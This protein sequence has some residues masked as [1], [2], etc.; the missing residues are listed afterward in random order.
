MSTE[1]DNTRKM[2]TGCKSLGLTVPSKILRL[3]NVRPT[4]IMEFQRLNLKKTVACLI[5]NCKS[6]RELKQIHSHITTSPH[7]FI[8]DR[9]FLISRL[10]FFCTVSQSGSLSYANTVFKLVPRKTLFIYNAMIRA[11][12]SRIHDPTSSQ[13]LILYKQMLFDAITPDSITFPF[14]LKHCANR[15][16]GFVGPSVHAHVV[17]FG[18]HSDVFV[19]N[20]LI[21]LYSQ[22]GSVE[23]ARRVFDEMS[24]RDIVSW[25]SIIIGCLR[26]GELDMALELFR[27]MKKR[28]IITWNSIITGFVQGGR[29]KE[30]LKLFY[31]MQVSDDGMVSPDKVTIASVISACASLGAV[32]QGKSVHDYLNRSGMECDMVIATALV[33]MYG[34]CGSVSRA[35]DVFRAMKNKDVL[36]WTVMISAFAING[37]G[38]EAFELFLEMEA[39]GVRPN[40][41]TFT[42]LLSAC[43]HSGLIE[44]GRW[45]F[46]V[47]K[48]AYH[49]EPQVQHY[50]CMVDILGRAGLF[51]EAEGL[52]RSMPMEPDVFVWGALLGGCQMHRNFRSGEKVAWYLITLEPLNHAFYVNLCDIYAK[53]GRFD[54]VKEVRALM[55]KKGIEK[56][57]P[58]CSTIE[59][60]GVVYEFSVR[61]SP[62]VL[63]TEIKSILASLSDEIG[64]RINMSIVLEADNFITK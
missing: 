62:Q 15:I 31:E 51:D 23:N 40:A 3:S 29:P 49:I 44:I 56:L 64:R 24:N 22:C 27:R 10:I 32:D 35:L 63:M 47:M 5:E 57:V 48:H 17:K 45:C 30:A 53:A 18:F 46:R 52:I 9:W 60:D 38:I 21:S 11:Y 12:A 1:A 36:A 39:A 28:N 43:A 50:A 34:K 58:G 26:K 55:K 19:Q 16:D 37:N 25:N 54:H 59:V 7:L 20:S 2:S 4:K 33:D 8:T 61:G 14:V 41:V 42:A 13:P 6:M